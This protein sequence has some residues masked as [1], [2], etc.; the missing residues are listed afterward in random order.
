MKGE[1]RRT[2]RGVA[3]YWNWSSC[4]ATSAF[5]KKEESVAIEGEENVQ[6]RRDGVRLCYPSY[7]INEWKS[8]RRRRDA[9]KQSVSHHGDTDKIYIQ[10]RR[11]SETFFGK[12]AFAKHMLISANCLD[13]P[14]GCSNVILFLLEMEFHLPQKKLNK[15]TER[16]LLHFPLV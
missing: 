7:A 14:M 16:L 12:F 2:E 9:I 4:H 3:Q 11:E 6:E 10:K 8:G 15:S 13:F 1:G 5:L